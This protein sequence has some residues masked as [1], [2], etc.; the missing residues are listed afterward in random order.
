MTEAHHLAL[1]LAQ[2]KRFAAIFDDANTGVISRSEFVNFARFLMV[3]SWLQTEDGQNILELT[4]VMPET[5]QQPFNG[6]NPGAGPTAAHA[7]DHLSVDLD[8]YQ[9]K[10]DKLEREN[11][12]QRS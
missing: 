7:V 4:T 6:R 10:A 8:F 1:D 9:Q 5:S 3:M 12:E 2:C 11:E